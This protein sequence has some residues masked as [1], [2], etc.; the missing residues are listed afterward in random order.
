MRHSFEK[1]K[2]KQ[3]K[4]ITYLVL[5]LCA[6]ITVGCN[7]TNVFTPTVEAVNANWYL[8]FYYTTIKSPTPTET[9]NDTIIYSIDKIKKKVYITHVFNY[10]KRAIF[11]PQARV[12]NKGRT[13]EIEYREGTVG[14]P[15]TTAT[16]KGT[17]EYIHEFDY[18]QMGKG[19]GKDILLYITKV[20]PNPQIS[21]SNDIDPLRRIS[22]N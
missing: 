13:I 12:V 10:Q 16:Q 15:N 4:K 1:S 8:D 19:T 6:F 11:T 17:F 22:F 14:E 18:E 20:F 3:M 21:P 7:D 2:N 9:K 5:V